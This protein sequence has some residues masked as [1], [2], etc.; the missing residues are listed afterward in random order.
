MIVVISDTHS[1]S[2]SELPLHL[3]KR[4][5]KAELVIHAGD[6]DTLEF[7]EELKSFDLVGVRGNCDDI[8]IPERVEVEWRGLRIGVRH[9]AD[10]DC[11]VYEA[12]ERD[13]DIMVFGHTHVPMLKI[14]KGI[15]IVN[16][17]SPKGTV[18]T[19]AEIYKDLIVIRTVGGD[20]IAKGR[21]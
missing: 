15:V 7:Y 4:L 6:F 16:P 21:R 10:P 14:V 20:V 9:E 17:G 5:E 13:L 18:P 3:L 1:K 8:D 19:F 11:L 2:L 12:M